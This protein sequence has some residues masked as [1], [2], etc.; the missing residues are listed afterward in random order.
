MSPR[1]PV[2]ASH[3]ADLGQYTV[4]PEESKKKCRDSV[5]LAYVILYSKITSEIKSK[6]MADRLWSERWPKLR[7]T[8]AVT[9]HLVPVALEFEERFVDSE[10]VAVAQLLDRV[11][12]IMKYGEII[13]VFLLVQSWLGSIAVAH[14]P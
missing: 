10:C 13:C 14:A 8:A 6:L 3:R 11:Y 7:A 9:R 4:M 1:K 2:A 5:K 12:Q